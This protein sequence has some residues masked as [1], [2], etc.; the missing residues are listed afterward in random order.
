MFDGGSQQ[1]AIDPSNSRAVPASACYCQ[2]S[3]DHEQQ[4]TTSGGEQREN[5]HLKASIIRLD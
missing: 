3:R 1:R 2:G 4:D 5:D